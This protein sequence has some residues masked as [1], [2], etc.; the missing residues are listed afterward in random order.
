[1]LLPALK[2]LAKYLWESSSRTIPLSEYSQIVEQRKLEE[3]DWENSFSR[4]LLDEGLLIS[5]EMTHDGEA[6]FFTYDMMAGYIIANF[7]IDE[8]NFDDPT[9][10]QEVFEMLFKPSIW[11]RIGAAQDDSAD[12]QSPPPVEILSLRFFKEIPKLIGRYWSLLTGRSRDRVSQH[13]LFRHPLA[14]D[15]SNCLAAT[16]L[17]RMGIY[18]H[19]VFPDQVARKVALDALF[20]ISPDKIPDSYMS[21][22]AKLFGDSSNRLQLLQ[23]A[24]LTM[25][26]AEHPLDAGFWSNLLSSLPLPERD[27]SWTEFVRQDCRWAEYVIDHLEQYCKHIENAVEND[28]DD[29]HLFAIQVMW[30]LT[31]TVRRVRDLA[32]RALYWYGRRFPDKLFEMTL[33]SIDLNDP[34]IRERMIAA[35]YG[36]AMAKKSGAGNSVCSD[37][38]LL[39][40]ARSLFDLMLA[41]GAPHATT[42][43]L[44]RDYAAHSIEIALSID[45]SILSGEEARRTSSPFSEVGLQ[46]WN[47]IEDQCAGVFRP[48]EDPM[49]T[50]FA[51]YTIGS[52]VRGRL[53]YEDSPEYR[54]LLQQIRWR[55]YDLGYSEKVFGEIDWQIRK[56]NS[57]LGRAANGRKID[58]YRKKYSWIAFFEMAGIREDQGML[59]EYENAGR[60]AADIDPSFPVDQE[61]TAVI[62]IDLLGNRESGLDEWI[63]DGPTPDLSRYLTIDDLQETKGPWVL[64]DGFVGQRDEQAHRK[65]FVFLRGLIVCSSHADDLVLD[66]AES[67]VNA[68]DLPRPPRDIHFFAG[69]VPWRY[70]PGHSGKTETRTIYPDGKEKMN[71]ELVLPVRDNVWSSGVSY[72]NP[73]REIS[74]PVREIAESLNLVGL[75]QTFNMCDAHGDLAVLGL[76]S[77]SHLYSH[78]DQTYIR[79]DLLEQYLS[80]TGTELVWAVWG[81]REAAFDQ[82]SEFTNYVKARRADGKAPWG[83]F[84]TVHRSGDLL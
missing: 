76:A 19:D 21:E 72:A 68:N 41:E 12:L 24:K 10:R 42:H 62:T 61:E 36:L 22:V 34:Y 14:E 7:L 37:E 45:T 33:D 55:I 39:T 8:G 28:T 35:V 71:Y 46:G 78:Q 64:L 18:F 9:W 81:E 52:L 16:L 59:R 54:T 5:R 49:Q 83:E 3:L 57:D 43:I 65:T 4:A 51:N 60:F 38:V 27:A 74:V 29:I 48:Y 6:I 20:E 50:D 67:Y 79:N 40:Y 69:E 75:P 13:A 80:Q 66:L 32:T 25:G 56:E 44:T 58:R 77:G 53:P 70:G 11:D 84:H 82:G 2:G 30:F 1:M 31:S 26:L 23:N 73:G 17:S 15:I 63:D 47:E